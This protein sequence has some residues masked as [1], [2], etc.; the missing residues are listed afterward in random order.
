MQHTF[1]R[2]SLSTRQYP[3]LEK[4]F[5][6]GSEPPSAN[7]LR[8]IRKST[9][10]KR[11]HAYY[12]GNVT[13]HGG[14]SKVE[15]THDSDSVVSVCRIVRREMNAERLNYETTYYEGKAGVASAVEWG[16]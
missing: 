8:S 2:T 6:T 11:G 7:V 9:A 15:S 4:Y 3:G 12:H 13:E 16:L 14:Q 10:P 1:G 5:S